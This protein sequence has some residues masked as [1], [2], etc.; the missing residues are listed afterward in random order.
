MTNGSSS[1][2][3]NY[4]NGV[5]DSSC[6]SA[7]ITAL[8]FFF[9][10]LFFFSPSLRYF[11]FPSRAS[12]LCPLPPSG[13]T[14]P[15]FKICFLRRKKSRSSR[16]SGSLLKPALFLPSIFIMLKLKS[17]PLPPIHV[18]NESLLRLWI[19][20]I[21]HLKQPRKQLHLT[22]LISITGVVTSTLA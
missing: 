21:C 4:W 2:R 5:G 12:M 8:L 6:G 16:S 10:H 13:K 20:Y 3:G 19:F 22:L 7:T 11:W 18:L 14:L 1:Y 15:P 17:T 9:F